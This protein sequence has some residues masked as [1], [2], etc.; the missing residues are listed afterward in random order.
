MM[1]KVCDDVNEITSIKERFAVNMRKEIINRDISEEK[2]RNVVGLK[3]ELPKFKG[4]DSDTDMYTFHT[5]I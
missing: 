5:R 4:Y 1:D 3:I 2:L